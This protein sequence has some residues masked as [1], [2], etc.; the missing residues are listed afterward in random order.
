MTHIHHSFFVGSKSSS[1]DTTAKTRDRRWCYVPRTVLSCSERRP[2]T[3]TGLIPQTKDVWWLLGWAIHL[4]NRLF[5]VL[6]KN[7]LVLYNSKKLWANN[8]FNQKPPK[9]KKKLRSF[10]N[11]FKLE[12][13]K[14]KHAFCRNCHTK[15]KNTL[16]HCC[17]SYCNARRCLKLLRLQTKQLSLNSWRGSLFKLCKKREISLLKWSNMVGVKLYLET[18]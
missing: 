7:P 14:R 5:H 9:S 1:N 12:V 10:T 18:V 13:N 6:W 17:G 4:K 11:A 15:T 3:A 8:A 16:D 2:P